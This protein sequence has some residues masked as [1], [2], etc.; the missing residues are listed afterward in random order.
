[1]GFLIKVLWQDHTYVLRCTLNALCLIC[2]SFHLELHSMPEI[3]QSGHLVY[4]NIVKTIDK[5]HQEYISGQKYDL[6]ITLSL[7]NLIT[8]RFLFLNALCLI[9]QD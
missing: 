4:N 6:V 7:Q 2:S 1:M 8:T 3:R 5:W 9:T